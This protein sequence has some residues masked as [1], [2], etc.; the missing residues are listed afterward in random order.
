ME[1]TRYE[2]MVEEAL[3][4]K[5]RTRRDQ[6]RLMTM[7]KEVS[8]EGVLEK[9][10]EDINLTIA[11]AGN[12]LDAHAKFLELGL[13][14][15][16]GDGVDG[17]VAE[18]W[19]D[20]F[21][22]TG[23]GRYGYGTVDR[24]GIDTAAVEL[25]LRGPTKAYDIAKNPNSLQAAIRGDNRASKAA[26]EALAWKFNHDPE[27]R[28]LAHSLGIYV[29]SQE[30]GRDRVDMPNSKRDPWITEVVHMVS[31]AARLRE[32]AFADPKAPPALIEY[33]QQVADDMAAVVSLIEGRIEIDRMERV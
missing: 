16:S 25:G 3:T 18:M 2:R 28:D 31:M 1:Q 5:R 32:K 13:V 23:D 11:G 17:V 12:Y 8:D 15:G 4:I 33:C 24:E 20:I 21:D 6:V 30:R 22:P 10:C 29:T 27:F 26:A 19:E 9:F 14:P 7:L